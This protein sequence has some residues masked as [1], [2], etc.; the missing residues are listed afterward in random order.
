MYVSFLMADKK[1]TILAPSNRALTRPSSPGA[2]DRERVRRLLL[3]HIVLGQA[4]SSADLIA[5]SQ[6]PLTL[7]TLGGSQLHFKQRKGK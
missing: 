5:K 6:Q 3:N 1:F 4:V 7:T 2:E